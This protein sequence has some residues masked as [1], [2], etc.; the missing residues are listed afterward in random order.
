MLTGCIT[1]EPASNGSENTSSDPVE[2]VPDIVMDVLPLQ[3]HETSGLIRY[4]GLIWTMNDS[5]GEP[6]IYGLDLNQNEIVQVVRIENGMNVDWEAL[7]SDERYIYIGDFGNNRGRR[8][9]LRIYRIAKSEIDDQPEINLLAEKIDFVYPDQENFEFGLNDNPHDC[10]AFICM[11]DSLILFSKDWVTRKTNVYRLP[12][13]PGRFEAELVDSFNVDGLVTG[14]DISPDRQ[15]LVLLGYKDYV[16][17]IWYFDK[18]EK[19]NLFGGNRKKF[20]IP[21]YFRAQT[22]GILFY[23]NDTLLF[24][25]EY[26]QLPARLYRYVLP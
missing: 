24:S 18:I 17:F 21:Q 7:T 2:I 23:S 15:R 20:I 10:E 16:P 1:R 22:E 5:G 25:S 6:A 19:N 14:A 9:D 13:I 26:S 4:K 12:A 8:T 3:L 11:D